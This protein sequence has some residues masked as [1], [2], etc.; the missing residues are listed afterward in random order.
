MCGLDRRDQI[1]HK[2]I[3][4]LADGVHDEPDLPQL[5][6]VQDVPPIEDERRLLHAVVD[7]L[8]IKGLELVPLCDHGDGRRAHAG[9]V[10][11]RVHG[12]AGPSLRGGGGELVLRVVPLKLAGGQVTADLILPAG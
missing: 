6:N 3:Q 10:G 1:L 8:V 4:W 11:R 2:R 12:D 5:R 7:L 9:L